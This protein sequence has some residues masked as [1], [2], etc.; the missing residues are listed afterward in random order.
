M[1]TTRS[2]K[3]VNTGVYSDDDVYR[4]SLTRCWDSN[5]AGRDQRHRHIRFIARHHQINSRLCD[6]KPDLLLAIK[7]L[8]HLNQTI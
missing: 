7:R 6:T 4:Y 1:P 2:T 5:L 3:I 8:E